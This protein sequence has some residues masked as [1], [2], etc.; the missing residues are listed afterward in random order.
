MSEIVNLQYTSATV[1]V[2]FY[3]YLRDSQLFK[4]FTPCDWWNGVL[5]I[6]HMDRRKSFHVYS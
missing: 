1:S 2:K 6:L 3:E 4:G 5:E